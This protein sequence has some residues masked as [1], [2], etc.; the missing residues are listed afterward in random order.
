MDVEIIDNRTPCTTRIFTC[1][2]IGTF[3]LVGKDDLY[4]KVAAQEVN[5]SIYQ[6]TGTL[7]TVN[8]IVVVQPVVVSMI[9]NKD[10]KLD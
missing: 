4:R 5:N 7:C 10:L 3:F 6:R 2:P 8:Q 9:I 1:I